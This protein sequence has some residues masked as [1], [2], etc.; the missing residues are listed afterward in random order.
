MTA[1]I[2]ADH[3]LILFGDPKSNSVLGTVLAR[4]PVKWTAEKLTVGDEMYD[5][6]THAVQL[7]HPNPQN[8]R[9]YVVINSGHTFHEAEF[10]KS[11]AWLIPMRGDLAVVRFEAQGEAF[12]ETVVRSEILTNQWRM[13][14]K[15]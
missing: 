5:P 14:G 3:N 11:N 1:E 9:R 6:A 2:I 10:R 4:L 13:P 12:R 8:P 15:K 7:I